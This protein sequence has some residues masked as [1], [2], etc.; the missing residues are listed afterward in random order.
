[1]DSSSESEKREPQPLDDWFLELLAC[2]ACEPHLPVTLNAAQDALLC[3]CGRYA[4]P[5]RDGIPILLVE[6]ATVL[7]ETI[8][9]G[10]QNAPAS[11][12]KTI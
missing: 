4:Y 2:P 9:P 11:G 8:P 12:E 7:D 3:G 6:E 5:I 10:G 1:M